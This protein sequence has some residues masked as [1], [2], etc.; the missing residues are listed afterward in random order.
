[1]RPGTFQAGDLTE[2]SIHLPII[3][4]RQPH[5]VRGQ[6]F[7]TSL[8]PGMP[9]PTRWIDQNVL[10]LKSRAPTCARK[11]TRKRQ[12]GNKVARPGGDRREAAESCGL[13]R[14]A[15]WR[16]RPSKCTLPWTP[17][18]SG[19]QCFPPSY[20]L[21]PNKMPPNCSTRGRETAHARTPKKHGD[22]DCGTT[23]P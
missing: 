17:T 10:E 19:F 14:G 3:S 9:S 8:E 21:W 16:P 20:P 4:G 11:L 7:W 23:S 12:K 13:R 18:P 5:P 15:S 22:G 1:M 6:M 2:P